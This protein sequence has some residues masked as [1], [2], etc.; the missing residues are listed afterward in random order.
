MIE[1]VLLTS[2]LILAIMMFFVKKYIKAILIYASFGTILSGVFFV[3]NAPDVAAVQMTI[4]SAFII[5]VYI[6]AIKTRSK[7]RVGYIEAPYLIEEIDGKLTG[8]EKEL[9][10][11]FSENSFFDVEYVKMDK[12]SLL[13][14]I[15]KERLDMIIGGISIENPKKLKL[16]FSKEYLPTKLFIVNEEIPEEF[17]MLFSDFENKN[18]M[19]YLR[20]KAYL[21][22]EKNISPEEYKSSGYIALFPKNNKAL[23]DEFNRFLKGFLSS[24]EYENIIRRN[25]G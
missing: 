19:D 4:G 22:K 8:F 14:N 24:K 13:E 11:N 15:K 20:L 12:N 6:I 23:K 18:L 16:L 17:K 10:E 5:F 9:I 1:I 2:L 21:R 7:I 25:L 3:F